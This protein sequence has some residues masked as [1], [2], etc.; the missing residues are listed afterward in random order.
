MSENDNQQKELLKKEIISEIT[1]FFSGKGE[2]FDDI[3][4]NW[5]EGRTREPLPIPEAFRVDGTIYAPASYCQ[6]LYNANHPYYDG[7][8]YINKNISIA[9]FDRKKLVIKFIANKTNPLGTVITG[10][11]SVNSELADLGILC[12]ALKQLGVNFKSQAAMQWWED[13][14]FCK[15][16]FDKSIKGPDNDFHYYAVL[17]RLKDYKMTAEKTIETS[18]QNKGSISFSMKQKAH[19][20]SLPAD[21]HFD[22]PI[23]TGGEDVKFKAE[24]EVDAS[25]ARLWMES[26]QLNDKVKED[27]ENIWLDQ[28]EIFEECDVPVINVS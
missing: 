20:G 3:T 5:R 14:K 9:I 23:W 16:L 21:L 24:W 19:E 28:K 8:P 17:A 1:K 18:A 4:V 22:M 10:K 25:N 13:L 15:N 7:E 26:E 12:P 2:I 6:Q 11:M 27:I